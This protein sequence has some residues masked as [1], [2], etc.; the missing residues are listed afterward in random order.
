MKHNT[1][2]EMHRLKQQNMFTGQSKFKQD[3]MCRQPLKSEIYDRN[4]I[5]LTLP[6]DQRIGQALFNFLEW[7]HDTKKLDTNEAGERLADPFSWE[8]KYFIDLWEEWLKKL[9]V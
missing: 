4:K 6:K 1:D 7:C 9:E 2:A 5:T 8:D 3:L